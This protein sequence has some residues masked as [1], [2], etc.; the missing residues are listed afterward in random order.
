[1]QQYYDYLLH[2]KITTPQDFQKALSISQQTDASVE[3]ILIKHFQVTKEAIGKSLSAFHNC[4]FIEYN[5]QMS[6]A[7]DL[8]TTLNRGRLLNDGWVPLSC[9]ENAIIVLVDDP[10]DVK[11][12][13]IIK[14]ALQTDGI[15][16]AVGIKED[17]EAFI[18][19]F[20]DQI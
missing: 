16:F 9:D 2:Q 4:Q 3:A 15:N 13:A 18:N 19:Q 10:S 12:M 8:F 5:P 14:D 17:I 7:D 6:R 11:K 20:F 1:M